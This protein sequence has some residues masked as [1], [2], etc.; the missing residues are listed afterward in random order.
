TEVYTMTYSYDAGGRLTRVTDSQSGETTLGYDPNG[1]W[2]HLA[3]PNSITT[4]YTYDAVNRLT[5]LASHTTLGDVLQSYQYTLGPTGNRTGISEH[6]GTSRHY[7]CDDLYRLTQDRVTGQA[8]E[9]VYQRDFTYDSV[10]NRLQQ[11]LD[12]GGGP[13]TIASSYDTRDR[14]LTKAA[15]T[16][17]W[18]S[19]GNLTSKAGGEGATFRW[20][21]DNRLASVTLGEGTLVEITYDAD[22]N[23]VRTAVTPP[24]GPTTA[25]D[26]LVD[27]SGPLSHVVADIV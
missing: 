22:G 11:V 17:G 18:D 4:S 12:E 6:D 2:S 25:V 15:A 5:A 26:H 1:N 8:G 3:L 13:T 20:D 23:R 7:A 24:G 16:F 14:L 21:N 19:N 9:L 10:G 27:T